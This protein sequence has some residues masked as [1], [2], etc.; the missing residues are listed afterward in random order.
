MGG[1][2]V[3][4]D[5]ERCGKAEYVLHP[6]KSPSLEVYGPE[7]LQWRWS[8][9]TEVGAGVKQRLGL[10]QSRKYSNKATMMKVA[11]VVVL[12]LGQ[13]AVRSG[14]GP[15]QLQL[16]Y[17]PSHHG[18]FQVSSSYSSHL[19]CHFLLAEPVF[20]MGLLK[21]PCSY[22]VALFSLTTTVKIRPFP[23]SST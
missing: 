2:E 19:A 14:P 1:N 4:G 22:G 23:S 16:Q 12:A 15:A 20:Y 8:Q 21:L 3:Q 18:L 11:G 17:R 6:E 5:D 7:K 9:L 10:L 13:V